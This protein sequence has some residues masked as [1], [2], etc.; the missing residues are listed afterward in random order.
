MIYLRH[1]RNTITTVMERYVYRNPDDTAGGSGDES[2]KSLRLPK[3]EEPKPASLALRYIDAPKPRGVDD[4]VLRRLESAR[5]T[6]QLVGETR[7]GANTAI[8]NSG[9][10]VQAVDTMV[11]KGVI[12]ALQ[13]DPEAY[14]LLFNL[15]THDP[16]IKTALVRLQEQLGTY[17]VPIIPA[18]DLDE[19]TLKE[20]VGRVKGD[21][22]A[23][24]PLV[25]A[26]AQSSVHGMLHL[27]HQAE[28]M[29]RE[30]AEE[31]LEGALDAITDLTPTPGKADSYKGPKGTALLAWHKL[32]GGY[33]VDHYDFGRDT[34][35]PPEV[36]EYA[37][38][39]PLYRA[40]VYKMIAISAAVIR[41]QEQIEQVSKALKAQVDVVFNPYDKAI[42]KVI[43]AY[44]VEVAYKERD[45]SGK[46][47][48]VKRKVPLDVALSH[49]GDRVLAARRALEGQDAQLISGQV[50]DPKK[51]KEIGRSLRD[52][53][54]HRQRLA[55]Q[56][57]KADARLRTIILGEMA[58]TKALEGQQSL[59]DTAR[60][61]LGN[62][63]REG[64]F[65]SV[66]MVAVGAE[67]NDAYVRLRTARQALSESQVQQQVAESMQTVNLRIKGM[68]DD[69]M[70]QTEE[71]QRARE[72]HERARRQI[73]ASSQT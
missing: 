53:T 11:H 30:Q 68:V 56:K 17:D 9:E 5:A 6:L 18:P 50:I 35:F 42:A 49:H 13:I 41:N 59:L 32:R 66:S 69:A 46:E 62:L 63:L 12:E 15:A 8:F 4:A 27:V 70:V 64:L 21:L 43:D 1:I 58:D 55:E 65:T 24:N 40:L 48:I 71:A 61:D 72:I 44:T 52:A 10:L 39:N 28:G 38:D 33:P 23:N 47:V 16:L 73:S 26:A 2:T 29:T 25:L 31:L 37:Q 20:Q 67:L 57:S 19:E 3:R 51:T 45:A 7:L 54:S 36:L 22:L 34:L 14:E 60:R